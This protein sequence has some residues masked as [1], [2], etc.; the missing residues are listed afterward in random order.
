[1]WNNGLLSVVVLRDSI[2][3]THQHFIADVDSVTV[4]YRRIH[5]GAIAFLTVVVVGF[6]IFISLV[7]QMPTT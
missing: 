6:G 2:Y 4:T 3:E 1:M 5:N 7:S